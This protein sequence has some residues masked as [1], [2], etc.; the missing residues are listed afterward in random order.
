MVQLVEWVALC[1]PLCNRTFPTNPR[2]GTFYWSKDYPRY[3]RNVQRADA[4]VWLVL[5]RELLLLFRKSIET[6]CHS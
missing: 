6:E 5:N 1:L 4:F 3:R 2:H